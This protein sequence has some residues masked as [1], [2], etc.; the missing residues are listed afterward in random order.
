MQLSKTFAS[1]PTGCAPWAAWAATITAAREI[2]SRW[3][4]PPPSRPLLRNELLD[5][6]ALPGVDRGDQRM[7]IHARTRHGRSRGISA[8][9]GRPPRG[10][11]G[12]DGRRDA[13][14]MVSSL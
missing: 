12:E 13:H 5:L 6:G 11:L 10:I 2:A 9:L 8:L 7:A 1:I 4:A 14:R 3:C